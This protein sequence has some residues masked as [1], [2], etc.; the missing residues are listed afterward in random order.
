MMQRL[1]QPVHDYQYEKKGLLV[2]RCMQAARMIYLEDEHMIDIR[3]M[4]V[5]HL[6]GM[7]QFFV[8][9]DEILLL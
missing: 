8:L 5:F 7:I 1:I 6:T 3:T 2:T 4:T 9:F